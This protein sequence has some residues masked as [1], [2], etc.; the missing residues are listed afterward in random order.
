MTLTHVFLFFIVSEWLLKKSSARKWRIHIFDP[1]PLKVAVL[2]VIDTP[3]VITWDFSQSSVRP[4][5]SKNNKLAV[6]SDGH[7]ISKFT[8][9]EQFGA[10][11]K[12]G[13][14]YIIRGYGLRKNEPPYVINVDAKTMFFRTSSL[15]VKDELHKE[16]EALVRPPSP[17]TPISEWETKEGLMSCEGQVVEASFFIA[18]IVL[19]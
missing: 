19:R 18:C 8:V 17:L 10:K 7:S 9:F 2:Q 1:P 5:I 12:E 3:K 6:V 4:G 15:S 14:T 13:N 16:A 11:L